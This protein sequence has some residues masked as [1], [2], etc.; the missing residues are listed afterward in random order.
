MGHATLQFWTCPL[1]PPTSGGNIYLRWL[2]RSFQLFKTFRI[3]TSWN[4]CHALAEMR[5]PTNRKFYVNSCNRRNRIEGRLKVTVGQSRT[6]SSQA[7]RQDSAQL[8]VARTAHH[9]RLS[10]CH[11][12]VPVST[13]DI[14]RWCLPLKPGSRRYLCWYA[15]WRQQLAAKMGQR[16]RWSLTE[17][18]VWTESCRSGHGLNGQMSS[19]TILDEPSLASFLCSGQFARVRHSA[20]DLRCIKTV[21]RYVNQLKYRSRCSESSSAVEETL[22][23]LLEVIYWCIILRQLN[24]C[25]CTATTSSGQIAV[26]RQQPWPLDLTFKKSLC[27][28]ALYPVSKNVISLF[29]HN[30]DKH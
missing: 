3:P 26:A 2:S 27:T 10:A 29:C 28:F 7:H 12:S 4:I 5:L 20:A 8:S 30:S 6:R 18:R 14:D 19:L 15:E 25:T 11:W 22:N 1:P 17:R 9:V 24:T 13:D 16:R 21:S 23:E